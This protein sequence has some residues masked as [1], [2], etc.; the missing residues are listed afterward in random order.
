[1]AGKAA[2][3]GVVV[4]GIS[5]R[6]YD[7]D[8]VYQRFAKGPDV[9]HVSAEDAERLLRLEMVVLPP[10][11]GKAKP[12]EE[13]VEEAPAPPVDPDAGLDDELEQLESQSAGDVDDDSKALVP[14]QSDDDNPFPPAERTKPELLEALKAAGVTHDNRWGVKRL[15]EALDA[16]T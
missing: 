15:A 3:V 13:K 1:M 14:E 11:A 5:V 12:V 4:T 10:K 16:A 8:G 9:V 7:S 6:A 2:P